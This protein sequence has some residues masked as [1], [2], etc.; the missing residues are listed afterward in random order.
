MRSAEA[1]GMTQCCRTG[2]SNSRISSHPLR[3]PTNWKVLL[4]AAMHQKRHHICIV[5]ARSAWTV[6]KAHQE[7]HHDRAARRPVSGTE[8]CPLAAARCGGST[9]S[10]RGRWPAATTS[11]ATAEQYARP[12]LLS[13]AAS[14]TPLSPC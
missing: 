7:R 11:V 1:S 5:P 13:Q 12:P 6:A 4:R 2:Q 14:R 3:L 8:P 9:R 10:G